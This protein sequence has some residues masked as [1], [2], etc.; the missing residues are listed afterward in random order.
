MA[1]Q[2]FREWLVHKS[3]SQGVYYS[4][5]VACLLPPAAFAADASW[6]SVV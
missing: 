5:A 6:K 1:Q 4:K 3:W 2:P